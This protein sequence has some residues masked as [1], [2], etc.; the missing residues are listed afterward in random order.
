M[1]IPPAV[2]RIDKIAIVELID[3]QFLLLQD[4]RIKSAK[5]LSLFMKSMN[6]IRKECNYY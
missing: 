3:I 6:K 4:Y 1:E 2:K 5:L